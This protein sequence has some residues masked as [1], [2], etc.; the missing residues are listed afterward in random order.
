MKHTLALCL[1]TFTMTNALSAALKTQDVSYGSESNIVLK[2]YLA[3]DDSVAGPRPGVLVVHEWWG[4]NAYARKRADKLAQL[5]YTALAV[6][7]YGDGKQ[8][9]HPEKA[10]KFAGAVSKN[11]E[12]AEARFRAAL[13]L[14]QAHETTDASRNAA[15][16]YCFGG[17]VVLNMARAGVDLDAVVSFHGSLGAKVKATPGAIQ[18]R[19]LVCNG[20]DDPFVSKDAIKSFTAEM[21]DVG[22]DMQFKS[23]AGAKHSFTN[24]NADAF[25]KKF[26]LPLAYGKSADDASW[27]DMQALFDQCFDAK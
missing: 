19:I 15:I 8:A 5:G 27:T 16:G 6:D 22:A 25:G 18:A 20:A 4:H 11:T 10:G 24:P 3:Y 2:G 17:G 26:K 23:Y 21:K 14:L 1:A 9:D 7:M 12:L 13:A